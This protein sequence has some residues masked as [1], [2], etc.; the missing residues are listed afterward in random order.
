MYHLNFYTLSR[1]LIVSDVSADTALCMDGAPEYLFLELATDH[2]QIYVETS[3][4]FSRDNDPDDGTCRHFQTLR[5]TSTVPRELESHQ[6]AVFL[7]LVRR[8]EF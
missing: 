3:D 4:P 1:L 5:K 8:P 6:I 7:D 2:C